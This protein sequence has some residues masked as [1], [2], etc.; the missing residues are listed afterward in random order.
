MREASAQAFCR[1][2]QAGSGDAAPPDPQLLPQIAQE[3]ARQTTKTVA[4]F[5]DTY[6]LGPTEALEEGIRGFEKAM[7]EIGLA[8]NHSKTK[9]WS[10][11]IPTGS[12]PAILEQY[13]VSSV[14]ALGTPVPYAKASARSESSDADDRTDVP[15]DVLLEETS[16]EDF[17][18]RQS[19]FCDRLVLL[20]NAGL[21]SCHAMELLQV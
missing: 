14:S 4:F 2:A 1:L 15:L 11:N 16:P 3:H 18:N 17:L 19:S 9:F 5:D 13:R 8:V 7:Q 10:P 20:R 12:A 21:S 6:L